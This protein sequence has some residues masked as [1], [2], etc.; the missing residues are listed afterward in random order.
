MKAVKHNDEE[1]EEEEGLKRNAKSEEV[2]GKLI[3]KAEGSDKALSKWRKRQEE[4]VEANIQTNQHEQNGI[5]PQ[6]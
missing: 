5:Q 1:E 3:D 6:Q 2:Q 4:R